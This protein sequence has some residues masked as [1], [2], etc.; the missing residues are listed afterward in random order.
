MVTLASWWESLGVLDGVGGDEEVGI[1][2]KS[3]WHPGYSRCWSW[4]QVGGLA[5]LRIVNALNQISG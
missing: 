1:L 3:P 5:Q 4:G 2:E